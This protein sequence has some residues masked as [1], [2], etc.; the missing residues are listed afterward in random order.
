MAA[1]NVLWLIFAFT[2]NAVLGH[3]PYNE[4]NLAEP[5]AAQ[6][7]VSSSYPRNTNDNSLERL[8]AVRSVLQENGVDAYIVPTADAH[9]SA[10]IAPSDARREW[11]SG[12]RGSS[13]TVLVTNSLALVWTDSRYFTQFENE[14]NLEHF[15]L[16]RQG[17]DESIQTWLV[18]NMGPYSVVG[19]DP[20]TYT[21]TAWNTLESALTAVNVTLQA[22]PDNLIDIARERIDDP[23]PARPNE[24]L[25]PLEITFTGRQSS[26]KLAELREQLS[27]RGVSAL[28]LTALDDVAYTLNLRGSDIPYNPVFF[29]YLILRSDLTAPN[30]TILFWGDGVLSSDIIEHLASEGTQLE[31][32]P[33]E[34]IFSYL[35]DMSNELPIG[36]TVWLSQDGSHAV[37]SAVETSGTVNILATLN[38]PVV[39][40]KCIKNEVELRG[41]RSAHVKDGIAAVRGFRWL[42]EQVASGVEVTEMDLSD[43]LAELRRNETDNYGP[44]FSTIAGA[45]ENGAMIHYSPSREGLQR[46]ITKDDMVLVDSGGQYKDGTTDLTRTRHM[47]GSPTPEQRRAFTLVMKGQIQLATTVFPR[48]TVGHTLE[49]FARKYLWDVGLTYGHGTG[50]GL[51]HFLNVHEGPSWILSGPIATDPGISAAM[52]FSNEPGYYEVGQYGIRHEDVV[53]VIVVDKNADHPMAEGMVGDFGGLG[54]LGFYTISLVPHQTACLDVNLLTDFEIKYLDDYHARVLATLGPILQ[55]RDL[56][57]DYAWLEKE[58]APIRSAAVR[59]TMPVL[60]V[61]FVSLWSYVN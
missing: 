45:G 52:I 7:Y 1:R 21:R 10:Y 12:L 2:A 14:V 42:E 37:Y 9:N 54:A 31:V 19:V 44:S 24:P 39:L 25:M 26:E 16:M 53:E 32:L 38:S 59:T 49:S 27:S 23:A 34:D 41:F 61:A 13:G 22:T 20:T 55:D 58:C 51:G 36:S 46:V 33:Y 6:Y 11:L 43:K 50:H 47:S 18:Q 48:G 29:S 5:E 30:N 40:M 8:T 57:E 35:G 60:L 56:L 3:I 15:T 17:I 4:Y 28:V